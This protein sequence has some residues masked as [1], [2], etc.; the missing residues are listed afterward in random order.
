MGKKTK[1]PSA[2]AKAAHRKI[3]KASL[4]PPPVPVEEEVCDIYF[5]IDRI[6]T[7]N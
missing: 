3:D 1:R 5:R 2:L 7:D 6:L 4:P